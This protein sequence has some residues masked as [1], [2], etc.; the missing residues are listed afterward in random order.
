MYCRYRMLEVCYGKNCENT[1]IIETH[2]VGWNKQFFSANLLLRFLVY[3]GSSIYIS[4][5]CQRQT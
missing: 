3:K 5:L 4:G 2:A 1:N